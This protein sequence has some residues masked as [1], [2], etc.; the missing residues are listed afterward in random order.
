[1]YPEHTALAYREAARQGADL[2]ECDLAITRD[3]KFICAHEPYLNLTTD[4]STKADFLDRVATYNMDDD[5]PLINWND[6]GNIT[7]WFSFDFDLAELKTLKKKQLDTFRDPGYDWTE[8]LVT[9]E[10]L[11]MITRE[12]GL[13]QGRTIGIYPEMKNSFA[14]NKILATRDNFTRFEDDVLAELERLGLNSSTD[15][16]F[17][18]SFEITGLEYVKDKTDMK[19]VFLTNNNL[20]KSN[21]ER[22]EKINLLGLGVDKGGLVTPGHP[23]SIGRGMYRWGQPTDFI[24]EVHS[25]GLK[26]HCFTFRN[27]WMKLYWESGQDPYSDLEEFL[28]LGNDGYFS[29]FPLTVRRFLHYKRKL[30]SKD[31]TNTATNPVLDIST[32]LGLGVLLVGMKL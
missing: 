7:D 28:A 16:V 23:D 25:H 2:V 10:E 26:V 5:D 21:W 22:L 30:C 12:E 9:L 31:E 3:K 1:M 4:I 19:L 14:I 13:K 15:P 18:Q 8:S 29:D 17:L 32:L 27:E 11:V 6:K 24:Q 20:T